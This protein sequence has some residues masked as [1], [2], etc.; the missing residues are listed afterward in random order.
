[1]ANPSLEPST[2]SPQGGETLESFTVRMRD[3]WTCETA[4]KRQYVRVKRMIDWMRETEP[5][6]TIVNGSLL[7]EDVYDAANK[8]S[9]QFLPI[10]WEQIISTENCIIMFGLLTILG[11]GHL[12]HVFQRHSI[13]DHLRGAIIQ[14]SMLEDHIESLA[15]LQSFMAN[16]ERRRWE[17]SPVEFNLDMDIVL[18]DERC[19]LPFCR[20]QRINQKGATASLF[21]VAV[22]EDFV[23]GN[24]R[25]VIQGSRFTDPVFGL[26]YRFAFK[27]YRE[28]W[29]D[30]YDNERNAFNGISK[31][32]NMI[33]CLGAVQCVETLQVPPDSGR[34]SLRKSYNILLEYG[35]DDLNEYFYVHSPPTL[36]RE[37]LD[38]WENLFQIADALQ[39]V[40]NLERRRNNGDLIRFEGYHA[41]VKPDNIL[42]VQGNFK[43]ADFGFATFK[44]EGAKT[45]L[46]GGTETYGAPEFFQLHRG[47][48]GGDACPVTNTIDT[49]SFACVMSVA[50]TWVVLGVQGIKQFQAVR[51]A[52]IKKIKLNSKTTTPHLLYDDTFH[53]GSA[54]LE[55]VTNWHKY[56]CQVM[57]KS[58]PIS[59]RL[60]DLID[61]EVLG[62]DRNGRLTS[63][64]LYTRLESL[65]DQ[66]KEHIQEEIAESIVESMISF[67][68]TA[69][70]TMEEYKERKERLRESS[71]I[72]DKSKHA[73]KSARLKSIV[74]VKVAH[75]Q[76]LEATLSQSSL[77]NGYSHHGGASNYSSSVDLA[78]TNSTGKTRELYPKL[79]VPPKMPQATSFPDSFIYKEY[80]SLQSSKTRFK[81]SS[82]QRPKEDSYL[83]N[84]I[85]DRDIKFIVDNGT[86]MKEHLD[87]AKVTLLVLAEKVAASDK[88]GI[89]LVFT[90][91]DH[92]LGCQ[93]VRDPWTRFSKAMKNA[94]ERIPT[95]PRQPLATDMARTLGE[96]FEEYEKKRTSKRMTL[97]ILTDGI[98]GGSGQPDEVEEK[99]AQFFKGSKRA[100]GFEDRP[101]TIQF[102]SFG[103]RAIDRLD[104]L[105]D[106][107]EKK[108]GIP[109]VIDH[110]P[111]TGNP[112]KMI[113]G[114]MDKNFD[115]S[116]TSPPGNQQDTL[117]IQPQNTPGLLRRLSAR[118]GRSSREVLT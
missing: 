24:L 98:W 113:L 118:S 67:D 80:L 14:K 92:L 68:K 22:E 64:E 34:A 63:A 85:K 89:D 49:W 8:H 65:L 7:L 41:D 111:C 79:L 102:V 29:Q 28:D 88:D 27:S 62:R 10:K 55:D 82:F 11:Y 94:D 112:N 15:E 52:A 66:A 45:S 86:S 81:F 42:R 3:Q 91:A 107:M 39:K 12:I 106:D 61:R 96:I 30:T 97:I 71:R 50:T 53:D 95:D 4:D 83:S 37:I 20:K 116:P 101:F 78:W 5:N 57:R 108:Y 18:E 13:H 33:K 35:E 40:H 72:Q 43:L 109:D 87:H 2:F 54:V 100:N 16:F 59:Y 58:D 19:V 117:T 48:A 60:L 90:F 69:P 104:A 17:F 23:Q 25:G 36:G 93:N 84:F 73:Q 114:S 38:F 77:G 51:E 46:V 31:E 56:L 76:I 105:D 26:C 32:Q 70:S 21:E 99:I 75:R 6:N 9:F 110:E 44:T 103:D 1:M 115:I 47:L 74:P